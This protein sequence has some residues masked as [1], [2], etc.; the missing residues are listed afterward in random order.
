ME[1]CEVCSGTLCSGELRPCCVTE[2]VKADRTSTH[3]NGM[4]RVHFHCLQP[5]DKIDA[6]ERWYCSICCD[7]S[8]LLLIL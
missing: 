2:D 6:M 5:M 1:V 3:C 7:V 4:S 8:T